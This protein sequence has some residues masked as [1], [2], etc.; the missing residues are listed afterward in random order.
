MT[1]VDFFRFFFSE[2]AKDIEMNYEKYFMALNLVANLPNL[3]MINRQVHVII[4]HSLPQCTSG[5]NRV[6]CMDVCVELIFFVCFMN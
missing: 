5:E 3:K 6:V 2:G 4:T 1:V